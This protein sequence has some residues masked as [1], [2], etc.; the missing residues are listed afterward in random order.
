MSGF[1]HDLKIA[2][3]ALV[4]TPWT[5]G[6]AVLILALGTGVNT[7]VLAVAYGIL[8]R[9]L[10]YADAS[11]IVVFGLHSEQVREY[12][13]PI[14]AFDEWQRRQ[15]TVE[16][17]AAYS[18]G[19]FTLRGLGDPR[20]VPAAIVKGEF[21]EV[22]G[23]PPAR[24]QT[25]VASESDRWIAVRSG[26]AK[27]LGNEDL[28]STLGRGVTVGQGTYVVSAVMPLAFAVPSE[29]VVAWFPASSLT[30][31]GFGERDAR[32]YRLIGR[33]KPGV[34]LEQARQDAT[35]VLR[36]IDVVKGGGGQA[37]VTPLPDVLTGSVRPVLAVLVGAAILVLLVACGNVASLLVGRAIARSHDLAVRL[38]LGASRWQLIRAVLAESLLIAAAASLAGV[39]VGFV[40]VRL[41]VGVAAD[42]MPRLDSVAIDL[43][44]LTASAIVSVAIALLCGAAPA[45]NVARHDFAHT[46]R[47]TAATASRRVR[48]LRA[49]I[50]AGQIAL[51]IVLLTGAGLV[52]RTVLRL[53]D[54]ATGIQ[55]K[56]VVTLRLVMSDTTSFNATSRIPLVRQLLEGARRLP[57]VSAAAIGSAL[58]PRHAPL[59]MTIR[60]RSEGRDETQTLTFASVTPGYFAALGGR[61]VRGRVFE[62]ADLDRGEPVAVLSQSA[63]RHLSPQRDPIDR[64]LVFAL[65]PDRKKRPRVIGIVRD[66]KFMGLDSQSSAAIYVLWTD[67]PA[68]TSYLVVRANQDPA[69]LANPLRRLIRDA[70]PSLPVPEV[71]SLDGDIVD[72]IADRRLRV[73][74]AVS[75]A[76]LAFAVALVGL[77]AIVGRAVAE[78]G[79]E[80]AIRGAV[81]ATP[82]GNVRMIVGEGVR[83]AAA[84]VVLGLAAAV[85]AGRTLATLLYGVTPYDPLTFAGVAV[86]VALAALGTCYLAARR[87][88][89][90]DLLQL[91]RE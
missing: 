79:R 17:L 55:P 75:F 35:R 42:V 71:R 68:S 80:F 76:C 88:L 32:S 86:L 43:P 56:N 50:V 24:G 29:R 8:L 10:P 2:F 54:Q 13:M 52:T 46:F 37:T 16:H 64:P 14:A 49:A 69:S 15:R 45:L 85:A 51:S 4:A 39:W 60:V 87:V 20:V 47:G 66:I 67:L 70:D 59:A 11:R 61:L 23:V 63:A 44:V 58:P 9:P 31:I 89:R 34:T 62:D 33:L 41:F 84:G 90:L 36:E 83:W 28:G 65:P 38:A 74:P 57:G 53:L 91:L 21:F 30:A 6:A 22:F 78:R 72:S 19:E 82:S 7:S 48:R 25:S 12:G 77:S 81:G 73:L 40:L 3:R 1:L 27:Q 26:L 18:E 5:T